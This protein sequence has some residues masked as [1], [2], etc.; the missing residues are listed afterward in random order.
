MPVLRTGR[1]LLTPVS[2][3]DLPDLVRLKRDPLAFGRMLGGVRTAEQTAAEL[4]EEQRYWAVHGVG[5]WAVREAPGNAV[6]GPVIGVT[7]LHDRA[8]NR[9]P[10]LRFALHPQAGGRGYAREAAGAA[11]R[12]AHENGVGLVWAV[13]RE[14]NI[15]SRTVLGAIGMRQ[16]DTFDR[17]GTAMMVYQSRQPG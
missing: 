16:V 9:S 1:L 4:V 8:D 17:G 14:D 10:A 5:I 7:G 11:L 3:G 15:A 6:T 2:Y 12:H 13:A